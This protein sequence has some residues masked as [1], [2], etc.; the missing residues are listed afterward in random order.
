MREV[1]GSS[2]SSSTRGAVFAIVGAAFF[3]PKKTVSA[4]MPYTVFSSIT[5]FC[6]QIP[7]AYKPQG[8]VL[9]L[10]KNY[11]SVATFIPH[12]IVDIF[13]L[14]SCIVLRIGV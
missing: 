9:H 11:L 12:I 13:R 1:A 2:P 3:M 6:L 10:F 4:V 7:V 8:A 14:N 5:V